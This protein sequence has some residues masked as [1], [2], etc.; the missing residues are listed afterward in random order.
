MNAWLAFLSCIGVGL[1]YEIDDPTFARFIRRTG[2]E[3]GWLLRTLDFATAGFDPIR[4]VDWQGSSSICDVAE[5]RSSDQDWL[6]SVLPHGQDRKRGG[7]SMRVTAQS[8]LGCSRTIASLRTGA[9]LFLL[10]R[11]IV[12]KASMPSVNSPT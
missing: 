3:S 2:G 6:S 11:A 8:L 4:F 9:P 12:R 7:R 1:D 5:R 10:G